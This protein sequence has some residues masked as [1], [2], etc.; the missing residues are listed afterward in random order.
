MAA[1][2]VRGLSLIELT[3]SASVGLILVASATAVML[4][5]ADNKKKQQRI[6]EVQADSSTSVSRAVY[7]LQRAGY[8]LPSPMFAV[9]FFDNYTPDANAPASVAPGPAVN[10]PR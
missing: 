5:M 4:S 8:R 3:V 10:W 2:K 9:R 7:D 6:V 1:R